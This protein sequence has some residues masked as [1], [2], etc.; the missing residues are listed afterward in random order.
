[1]HDVHAILSADAA[2]T[3]QW[4]G[5]DVEAGA[6]I[7]SDIVTEELDTRDPDGSYTALSN[8]LFPADFDP[9]EQN[10]RNS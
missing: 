4:A 10:M 6:A 1:M 7:A 2:K 3:A 5:A 8:S 9:E